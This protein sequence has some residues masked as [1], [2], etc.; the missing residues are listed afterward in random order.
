MP[1]RQGKGFKIDLGL[2]YGPF[3]PQDI[4]SFNQKS[5]QLLA[6]R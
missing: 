4:S 6:A 2:N 3:L 5:K 1:N